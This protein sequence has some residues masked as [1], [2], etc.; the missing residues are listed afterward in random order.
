MSNYLIRKYSIIT[1]QFKSGFVHLTAEGPPPP[2]TSPAKAPNC[3]PARLL[4][5]S[6]PAVT[7]PLL[8]TSLSSSTYWIPDGHWPA[9][10]SWD[11]T[12][13]FF[14]PETSSHQQALHVLLLLYWIT[15]LTPL[16][17]FTANPENVPAFYGNKLITFSFVLVQHTTSLS[18][19]NY[20]LLVILAMTT[21]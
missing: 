16:L 15:D 4:A 17:P 12:V 14:I 11:S 3:L 8:L 13:S 21:T 18:F 5:P 1:I 6:S 19:T 10:P 9:R 2:G 20:W 7:S